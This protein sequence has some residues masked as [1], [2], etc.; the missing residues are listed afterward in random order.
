MGRD[1]VRITF[2]CPKSLQERLSSQAD[3]EG[4]PR[5]QLIIE[6]LENALG[7]ENIGA[8]EARNPAVN[9]LIFDLQKRLND[10]EGW[11][12]EILD[13]TEKSEI[14][15]NNL[16]E[17][18]AELLNQQVTEDGKNIKSAKSNKIPSPRR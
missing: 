1:S 14:N 8:A 11:R 16:E 5:S 13:W 4:I 18:L 3:K 10:I 12:R 6:L 15:T 7:N 2:S 9:R 17:T